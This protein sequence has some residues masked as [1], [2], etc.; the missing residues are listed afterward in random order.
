MILRKRKRAEANTPRVI[1]LIFATV[2]LDVGNVRTYSVGLGLLF[3]RGQVLNLKP[4]AYA[5]SSLLLPQTPGYRLE[6]PGG[7]FP[8]VSDMTTKAR[9]NVLIPRSNIALLVERAGILRRNSVEDTDAEAY[10]AAQGRVY[11]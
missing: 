2:P 5:L 3:V 4:G 7:D 8:T 1:D 6:E 9:K 11:Q 10:P